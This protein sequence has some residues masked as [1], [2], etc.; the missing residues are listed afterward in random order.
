MKIQSIVAGLM[1]V[2]VCALAPSMG[3][4]QLSSNANGSVP[5]VYS[6]VNVKQ[7]SIYV[8]CGLKGEINASLT[9][10]DSIPASF[11]WLKYNV[12]TRTFDFLSSDISGSTTSTISALQDGAY[13]VNITPTGGVAATYTAWVFN[14][15]IETTAEI[16]NSDCNSFTL[17]GTIEPATLTYVDL[18]TLQQKVLNKEPKAVWTAVGES[19][20]TG[21]PYQVFSPPT[22]NTDYT[23]TVTDR[24]GCVSTSVVKYISIVTKATFTA[25]P[26][27]QN[28][29]PTGKKEAPLTVDF[30]NTEECVGCKYEWFIFKDREKIIRESQAN[31]G[32][33]V[34]SFLTKLFSD[35]P[36]TYVFENTG[37]YNVKLVSQ[38]VSEFNT[39]YDTVYIT[40]PISIDTSFIEAPNFFTPGNNDGNN[41]KFLIRFFSM[42]TVKISIFNRWGK[43]VHVWESNN[44]QGFGYTQVSEPQS[45]W[46][47]KIGGKLAVPGVYFY[48]VEGNGRDDKRRK[49]NGFVH[50]FR[51]K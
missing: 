8:F 42:K 25:T 48:V 32:Q 22:K 44:V 27:E 3:L 45:V 11:E 35:G 4:A 2:I 38:K 49:T 6:G 19:L 29:V 31:P 24:F 1:V 37:S 36:I 12:L 46:D 30:K 40:E 16:T 7:D 20:G 43:M 26:Q 10:K 34:D 15:Y 21:L 41:D 9:A 47:G 18:G 50:L 28:G 51:E 39:C 33:P 13:R 17:N 14:N 23:L 5:T